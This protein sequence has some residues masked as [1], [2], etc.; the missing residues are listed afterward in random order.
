MI[1]KKL[2]KKIQ[3][4][5]P[6]CCVDILILNKK[7]EFLLLKRNNE[8]ARGLWW[9]PGGRILKGELIE[10]AAIRKAEEETGLKVKIKKLIGVKETIFKKGVFGKNVHT[11]NITFLAY[12]NNNEVKMDNQ[13]SEYKWFKKID[14]SF[15]PYIKYF[16]KQGLKK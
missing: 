3:E 5:I 11:V 8:P 10:K 2:Y 14:K 13:N 16:I 4:V 9:I 1:N 12:A 15:D 7:N 6:I